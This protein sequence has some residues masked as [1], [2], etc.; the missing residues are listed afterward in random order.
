M[1]ARRRSTFY[2]AM[3]LLPRERREALFALY[4]IARA[5]DDVADGPGSV[6]E[7]RAGL[8]GWRVQVA[9][10]Y[11][12]TPAD[13]VALAFQPHAKR[14]GLPRAELDTLIDGQLMDLEPQHFDESL[15]VLYCR[16]VAGTVGL[17]ALP[18]FGTDSADARAYAITLGEALQRVNVLRDIAEDAGRGRN[19]LPEPRD[20]FAAK[21]AAKLAEARAML[22]QLDRPALR[23]AIVMGELYST[24]LARMEAGRRLD[25][26]AKAC[27]VLRGLWASR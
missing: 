19:Y 15:F 2:W 10:I 6:D 27:A 22:P 3:R 1:S 18:I 9:A 23:P 5:I 25:G 13:P 17:L 16:R 12:G 14:F 20:S 4:D 26:T 21:A 7:R 8:A 11:E 24:L